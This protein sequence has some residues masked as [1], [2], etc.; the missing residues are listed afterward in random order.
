MIVYNL[1]RVKGMGSQ[2]LHFG[3]DDD[4]RVWIDSWILSPL[5]RIIAISTGETQMVIDGRKYR[6]LILLSHA[7]ECCGD[8]EMRE[9]LDM[10]EARA[11]RGWNKTV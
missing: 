10:F 8:S 7:K 2:H 3:I 6:P 11:R 9:A 4:N 5:L 1:G